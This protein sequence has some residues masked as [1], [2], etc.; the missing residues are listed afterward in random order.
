MTRTHATFWA[1]LIWRIIKGWGGGFSI[2][3]LAIL[4][5]PSFY[6]RGRVS[7]MSVT[8]SCKIWDCVL[9]I[10]GF[11]P[12]LEN[13]EN[14]EFCYL[15]FQAWKMPGICSKS[16]KSMELYL[17]TWTKLFSEIRCFMIHFSRCHL[18]KNHLHRCHIYIINKT[19]IQG[20]SDLGFHCFYL[21]ITWKIHGILCHQRSKNSVWL[22][23]TGR[24]CQKI[25]PG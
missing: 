7:K 21:E 22:R 9:V 19:L 5:I 18:Q 2:L 16:M 12:Y 24:K 1:M 13:H 25:G 4:D 14:L 20:Q 8:S 17:K 11:P 23:E 3:A 6:H 15:L 10:S